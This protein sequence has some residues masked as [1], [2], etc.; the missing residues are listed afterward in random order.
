MGGTETFPEISKLFEAEITVSELPVPEKQGYAFT[1]WYTDMA[2]G[3]ESHFTAG[4]TMPAE[5]LILYAGWSAG[6][7][8]ITYTGMD[9][10]AFGESHP[11]KHVYG[12]ET[13]VS[14]PTKTG[15]VFEGWRINGKGEH[16][17]D[18]TLAADGYIADITLEATWS[19][20]S[21][22]ISYELDGGVN[23]AANSEKHTYGKTTRIADPS[24]TGYTFAGWIVNGSGDPIKNLTLSADGYTSGITLTATWSINSYTITFN[25]NGGEAVDPLVTEYQ[26]TVDLPTP[27]RDGYTFDGWYKDGSS[28]P[29]TQYWMPAEDFTLTAKW[30]PY[31]YNIKYSVYPTLH[32]LGEGRDQNLFRG[33]PRRYSRRHDSGRPEL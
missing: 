3:E 23:A 19:A 14:D 29:Y 18:L 24:K 21:Y 5:D 32:Q 16:V 17:R 6:E 11:D 30:T 12:T 1:G 28:E 13:V 8:S 15:Y 22:D 9:N 4:M 10:A 33:R 7:Y 27:K 20:E 31:T 2:C 26:G 25:S